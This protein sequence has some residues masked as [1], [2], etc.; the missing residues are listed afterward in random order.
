MNSCCLGDFRNGMDDFM[1]P[2]PKVKPDKVEP[3]SRK[4]RWARYG[5]YLASW[6][7][8]SGEENWKN[9]VKQNAQKLLSGVTNKNPKNMILLE[10]LDDD[11]ISKMSNEDFESVLRSQANNPVVYKNLITTLS[12]NPSAVTIKPTDVEK[13]ELARAKY[14]ES[15]TNDVSMIKANLTIKGDPHWID[16]YMPPAVAK[17]EFG[18]VGAVSNKGYSMQTTLNGYNYLILKSGVAAGTDLHNNI[19]KRNLNGCQKQ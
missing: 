8:V 5:D 16:G 13:V 7:S 3:K 12:K 17:R 2:G 9:G 14:Y 4:S 10:E 19:L 15:K 18:D 1:K 11:I 6:T